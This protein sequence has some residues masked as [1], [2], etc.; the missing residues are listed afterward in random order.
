MALY[1]NNA[2]MNT[3]RRRIAAADAGGYGSIASRQDPRNTGSVAYRLYGGAIDNLDQQQSLRR[4]A[5]QPM[6]QPRQ[7]APQSNFD[8]LGYIRQMQ[9]NNPWDNV[10]GDIGLDSGEA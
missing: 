8:L 6:T 4:Q 3:L 10:Y 5:M 2:Q 1:P 7:Q 9:G